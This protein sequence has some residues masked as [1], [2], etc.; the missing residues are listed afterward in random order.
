MSK[1]QP[2]DE[3]NTINQLKNP[4]PLDGNKT[5][6]RHKAD[7]ESGLIDLMILEGKFSIEQ[8]IDKLNKN[9]NLK[10]K[11]RSK[12]LKRIQDHILHLKTIEGDSRNLSSG[13]SGHNIKIKQ[14]TTGEILFDY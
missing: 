2:D 4:N 8:M 3:S 11:N 5:W 6:L 10:I 1:S 12:W 9:P 13:I 7:G 14:A